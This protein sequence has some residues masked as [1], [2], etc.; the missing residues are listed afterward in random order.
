MTLKNVPVKIKNLIKTKM[1][2]VF[3]SNECIPSIQGT[4]VL[5]THIR[6]MCLKF[7]NQFH[8]IYY[9]VNTICW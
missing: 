7:H 4:Y 1:V 9:L 5:C 3:H 8:E 2:F 6:I